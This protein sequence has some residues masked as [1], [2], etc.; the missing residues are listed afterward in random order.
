[1]P[2]ITKIPQNLK[3]FAI[4]SRFLGAGGSF[5]RPWCTECPI[6][7]FNNRRGSNRCF[8][9]EEGSFS[10]E[11][12]GVACSKNRCTCRNGSPPSFCTVDNTEI[13]EKCDVGH[14]FTVDK[15]CQ[16]CGL[17]EYANNGFCKKCPVQTFNGQI[18]A[19]S[20]NSCPVGMHGV[21]G[22]RWND[23]FGVGAVGNGIGAVGCEENICTCDHGTAA[24]GQTCS[25]VRSN[26]LVRLLKFGQFWRF[27]E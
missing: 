13:C 23:G 9:C 25:T 16:I 21:G 24:T 17:G 15:K 14:G 27:S 1:M 2:K 10:A 5:L 7:Y 3:D 18:G 20:C 12:A 11:P 26:I 19:S 22:E 6:N 4:F 8:K